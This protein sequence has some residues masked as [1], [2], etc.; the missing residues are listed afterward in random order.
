[1]ECNV[2]NQVIKAEFKNLFSP[3]KIGDVKIKNR[4]IRSATTENMATKDG[5]VNDDLIKVYTELAQ[6]GT[7]LIITGGFA[8]HPSSTLRRYSCCLYDDVFL[9]GQ[10]KLV[11]AVHD[12]SE[13][14][15][16]AQLV[17]TGRQ[18]GN[19]K[20]EP[21]APSPITD[22]IV[23]RV[24][25]ELKTEEIGD[26]IKMFVNAGL[27]AYEVGYDAVQLHAA[28]GFLLSNFISP[29]SNKRTDEYGGDTQRRTKILVEI[30]DQLRDKVG[31]NFPITVKLQTQGS[32]PRG[33]TLEEG[34]EIAKIVADT[35]YDAI[36]P[37]GGGGESMIGESGIDGLPSRV[38]KSPEDENYFLPTVNEIKPI[39]N[40]CP[41]IL[42]GGVRNPLSAEKILREK[43]AEFISMS[44]PLIYEPNLPNRWKNGD[45]APALCTSCNECYMSIVVGALHC[46]YA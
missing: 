33:L 40:D 28:H 4:I 23:N 24:P 16:A 21:V 34:K 14:R 19:K 8:V 45:T 17:H 37:S 6:G 3:G 27:R 7:G 2:S 18:T 44:R 32:V 36:E 25:R 38:I 31:K 39:V 46:I 1:M 26:V 13:C 15:I 29:Y 20:Y 22:K 11:E 42:M 5:Q 41:V 12:Y 43:A 30:Y 10:K 35:G 9:P